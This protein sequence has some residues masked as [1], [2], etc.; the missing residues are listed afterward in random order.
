MP[1]SPTA[2]DRARGFAVVP[3]RMVPLSTIC[4]RMF[5]GWARVLR[6]AFGGRPP[7]P[8]LQLGDD[9][10]WV[11]LL[12]MPTFWRAL[13]ISVCLVPVSKQWG[14]MD[15]LL[16]AFLE[17]YYGE[18]VPYYSIHSINMWLCC[19][20]PPFIASL[21]THIE[22]FRVM[23]PGIWIMALSPI[24][25]VLFPGVPA[26]IAWI[27]VMSIGEMLWSPRQGAWTASLAPEG[28]EG[29]FLALLSLKTLITAIPATAL[30]GWM[31][32]Q[33]V[34]NCGECRDDFGHF[35]SQKVECDHLGSGHGWLLSGAAHGDVCPA[36]AAAC[37]SSHQ[38]CAGA[39]FNPLLSANASGAP[40]LSCP[41]SCA[42]CPGWQGNASLMWLICVL[43]SGE[44]QPPTHPSPPPTP[45]PLPRY[46]PF[47]PYIDLHPPGLPGG[48]GDLGG[49]ERGFPR[50]KISQQYKKKEK[51]KTF[52]K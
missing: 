51:V 3:L 7:T 6:R 29:V 30:N 17:R 36:G 46:P 16:P 48:R 47:P 45:T 52:K 5:E 39:H 18:H 50:G 49:W 22:A 38:I 15:I 32:Q 12:Q 27:V 40:A 4:C 25:L 35:C 13:W 26:S 43:L 31:N 34:P 21:T 33:F 24:G 37:T 10:S 28:R 14:D 8:P 20:G 44:P 19:L 42:D 9:E 2:T 41:M 1:F 23:L 11:G